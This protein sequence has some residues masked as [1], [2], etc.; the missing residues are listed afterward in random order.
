MKVVPVTAVGM[1]HA[2]FA[3]LESLLARCPSQLRSPAHLEKLFLFAALWAIGGAAS[4]EDGGGGG[5]DSLGVGPAPQYD[6]RRAF[7]ES[8][9]TA[10][11]KV[12]NLSLEASRSKNTSM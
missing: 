3:L 10:F 11:A 1:L 12:G 4:S 8:W 9:R 5:D 6:S 2:L 7:S